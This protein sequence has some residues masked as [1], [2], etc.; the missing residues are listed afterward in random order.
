MLDPKSDKLLCTILLDNLPTGHAIRGFLNRV[1]GLESVSK[2]IWDPTVAPATYAAAAVEAVKTVAGLPLLVE[3]LGTRFPHEQSRLNEIRQVLGV[4]SRSVDAPSH[5]LLMDNMAHQYIGELFDAGPSDEVTHDLIIGDRI[6]FASLPFVGV[7]LDSLLSVLGN[8]VLHE[9]IC[10]EERF[11][12]AWAGWDSPLP[13]LAS[14]GILRPIPEPQELPKTR[15]A[16]YQKLLVT[17]VLA[18]THKELRYAYSQP[19]MTQEKG[20]LSTIIWGGI[21]Y[22]ARSAQL[23][24]PYVAHPV[25]RRFLAQTPFVRGRDAVS[26]TLGEID[27]AHAERLRAIERETSVALGLVIPPLLVDI[28]G[29]ATDREDLLTVA[30]QRR[31]AYRDLRRWLAYF[32]KAIRDG[33]AERMME[34][35]ATIKRCVDLATSS[36]HVGVHRYNVVSRIIDEMPGH[37]RRAALIM[38][39]LLLARAGEEM[40][41]KLLRFFDV[42][43]TSL[44]APVAEYLRENVLSV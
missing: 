37:H 22:L 27:R 21:G 42:A 28:I 12:D 7:A 10:V 44:E 31:E 40:T 39:K 36:E 1:S 4:P 3:A 33:D 13:G 9:K 17:P 15:S 32:Q 11:V 8:L 5:D 14:A 25:R 29:D 43:G 6:G 16:L 23:G 34:Y 19:P 24:I 30:L 18:R 41:T 35:Q 38:D 20:Y 2:E 26:L